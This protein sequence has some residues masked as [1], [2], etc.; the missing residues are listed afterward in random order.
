MAPHAAIFSM[1]G[2]GHLNPMLELAERLQQQHGFAI[3]VLASPLTDAAPLAR[4]HPS[5]KFV[6]VPVPD[7]LLRLAC[8]GDLFRMVDSM[9]GAV[10]EAVRELDPPA[11]MVIADGFVGWTQDVAD[12]L[13]IAR[14]FF[15]TASA[16]CEIVCSNILELKSR[17]YLPVKRNLEDESVIDFLPGLTGMT[18]KDLPLAFYDDD[19]CLDFIGKACAR[20]PEAFCVLANTFQEL[21][22]VAIAAMRERMRYFAIGPLIPRALLREAQ[23]P[24]EDLRDHDEHLG[25]MEWLDRQLPASI[26]YIAFGSVAVLSFR[27]VKEILDALQASNQAFLW[28]FRKNFVVDVP[29][30]DHKA[31]D[32]LLDRAKAMESRLVSWA[33]QL[34][35]LRHPAV[36]GFVTHCGWNSTMEAISSG[37]PMLAWPRTSEQNM[38]S[39]RMVEEWKIALGVNNHGQDTDDPPRVIQSREIARLIEELNGEEGKSMKE[40]V[41]RLRDALRAAHGPGGSACESLR[42]FAECFAKSR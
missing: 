30:N 36:V 11:T 22:P 24:R 16:A 14:V 26:L 7:D 25:C 18:R 23:L 34:H 41:L 15:W 17:G 31:L 39:K 21:E 27:Q 13:G 28:S 1:D 42:E 8:M 40:N 5:V 12:K 3:T 37:V 4:K 19:V 10:E 32:E 33:P 20:R 2:P 38:N 9:P 29:D 6:T 35:V